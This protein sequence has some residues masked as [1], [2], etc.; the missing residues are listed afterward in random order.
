MATRSAASLTAADG[1][2]EAKAG[3]QRYRYRTVLAAR[4]L[5]VLVRR[6]VGRRVRA[7][8]V[9]AVGLLLHPSMLQ[10]GNDGVRKLRVDTR[11]FLRQRV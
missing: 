1:K 3:L 6:L 4:P 11:Q 2:L 9:L 10:A 7:V 8:Q 5:A